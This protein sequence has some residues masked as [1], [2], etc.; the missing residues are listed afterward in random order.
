MFGLDYSWLGDPTYQHWLVVG[1][2][3]TIQLAAISSFVAVLIGMLGALGL[4]LRIF[5]LDALIELLSKCFAILRLCCKCCFLIS[6]CR[7]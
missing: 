1:V 5:W 3:N 4:T 6:P 2:L 7:L